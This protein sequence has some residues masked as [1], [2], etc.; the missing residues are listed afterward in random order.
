MQK[1]DSLISFGSTNGF[2]TALY[3][4]SEF[5][6]DDESEV[7]IPI[8]Y[9]DNLNK[10]LA[11]NTSRFLDELD[12]SEDSSFNNNKYNFKRRSYQEVLRPNQDLCA[13]NVY[14]RRF[15]CQIIGMPLQNFILGNII[16]QYREKAA[17]TYSKSEISSPNYSKT[18][19]MSNHLSPKCKDS[20]QTSAPAS[21]DLKE[22]EVFQLNDQES[23]KSLLTMPIQSKIDETESVN[24]IKGKCN[25]AN[26]KSKKKRN[27]YREGDWICNKC[28]NMNFS[29]RV[30]CNKC[31]CVKNI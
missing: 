31:A 20:E 23:I 11:S 3:L 24:R 19:E 27:Q 10:S 1:R 14:D 16:N 6:A 12:V 22:I 13:S 18:E 2:S 5:K 26:K 30:T 21:V 8:S 17:S 28:Q 4:A 25:L 7:W 15:S 29:F 9:C